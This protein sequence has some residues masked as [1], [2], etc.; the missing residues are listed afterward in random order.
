MRPHGQDPQP[1]RRP[2]RQ[3]QQ[4]RQ[5]RRRRLIG[6]QAADLRPQTSAP[7]P[8]ARSL[9]QEPGRGRA[10]HVWRTRPLRR[11]P[12]KT[13]APGRDAMAGAVS[14]FC[15]Y[16]VTPSRRSRS[17]FD[18]VQTE[19]FRPLARRGRGSCHGPSFVLL[20]LTPVH[21]PARRQ[22]RSDIGGVG[23]G[24]ASAGVCLAALVA[25]GA[26][27]ELPILRE[28]PDESR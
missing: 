27:V 5:R 11:F 3:G 19:R 15:G 16:R 28:V 9:H 1:A 7:Q 2:G 12:A 17:F 18:H 14:A 8:T 22:V 20:C 26:E 21:Y 4:G 13:P 24:P 6:H 10:R 25:A 23:P